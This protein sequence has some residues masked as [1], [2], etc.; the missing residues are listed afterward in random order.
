MVK[1]ECSSTSLNISKD[2][3]KPSV[4]VPTKKIRAVT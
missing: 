4:E 3:S 2:V 1:N